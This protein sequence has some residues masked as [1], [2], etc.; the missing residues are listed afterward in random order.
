MEVIYSS[1]Q[2]RYN[3]KLA[4]GKGQQEGSGAGELCSTLMVYSIGNYQ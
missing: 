4:F 2:N 3:T 1:G